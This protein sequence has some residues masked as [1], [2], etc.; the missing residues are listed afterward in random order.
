MTH[1]EVGRRLKVKKQ[2]SKVPVLEDLSV[3]FDL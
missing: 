2:H 1:A 3:Y